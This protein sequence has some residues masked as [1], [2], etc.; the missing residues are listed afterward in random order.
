MA[1]PLTLSAR[2]TL[3][4]RSRSLRGE[5][6]LGCLRWV[7]MRKWELEVLRHELLDVWTTDVIGLL[8][9]DDFEDL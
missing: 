3:V 9:F 4:E 1:A 6:L 7:A 2:S 5:H 8:D